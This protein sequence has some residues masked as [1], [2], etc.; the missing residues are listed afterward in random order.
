MTWKGRNHSTLGDL[1]A[2]ASRIAGKPP[3]LKGRGDR[4]GRAGAQGLH[5]SGGAVC[6]DRVPIILGMNRAMTAGH[7]PPREI[8][9]CNYSLPH[10]SAVTIT[11]VLT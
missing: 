1:T 8:R 3:N 7:D 2:F 4:Y 6:C 9:G 5:V 11:A 10:F